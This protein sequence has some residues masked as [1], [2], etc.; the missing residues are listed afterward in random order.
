MKTLSGVIAA[1]AFAFA[2]NHSTAADWHPEKTVEIISGVAPGG[3]LDIMA[4]AMQ[5]I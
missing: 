4:R 3:A 1:I 5:K 2:A